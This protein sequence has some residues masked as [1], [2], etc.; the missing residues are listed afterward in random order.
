[1]SLREH[2]KKRNGVVLW[3]EGREGDGL[4]AGRAQ[5]SEPADSGLRHGMPQNASPEA[6]AFSVGGRGSIGPYGE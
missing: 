5:G 3:E 1:M 2:K 4:R 6:G